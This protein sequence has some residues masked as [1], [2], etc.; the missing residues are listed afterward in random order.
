LASDPTDADSANR[1][2]G[3]WVEV[4]SPAGRHFA[5]RYIRRAPNPN[6]TVV[7]ETSDDL[8][9][10]HSGALQTVTH[11]VIDHLDGTETVTERMLEPTTGVSTSFMRVKV[12]PAGGL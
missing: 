3:V 9:T 6:A 7:V 4:E 1:P 5:V 10:W 8:V 2:A 12:V 11:E